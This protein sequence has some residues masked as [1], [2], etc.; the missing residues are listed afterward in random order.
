MWFAAFSSP[1]EHPWFIS[2]MG[3]LLEGDKPVLGL[4]RVNPFP[5]AP[6]KFVRALLYEYDFANP[7]EHSRTGA[8]WDRKL[9]SLYFPAVSLNNEEFRRMFKGITG[10]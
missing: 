2:L 5:D 4:L 9:V 10:E 7:E 3:K 6:P 1:G 8:I